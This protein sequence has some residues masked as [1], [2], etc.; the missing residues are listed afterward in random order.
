ME[1]PSQRPSPLRAQRPQRVNNFK[2]SFNRAIQGGPVFCWELRR[3]RLNI[4]NEIEVFKRDWKFQAG[5]FFFSRFSGKK[6]Q[7]QT[8]GSGY[9]PVVGWRSSMWRRGGPRSS[10]CPISLSNFKGQPGGGVQKRSFPIW[11]RLSFF[12]SV[13]PFFV[14]FFVLSL[15]HRNRSDVCDF[16]VCDAHR[17][18]QKFARFLR[19]DKAMLHCDLKVRW[20]VASDLRF[21]A[22][23]SEPKTPSFCGI[24]GDLAQSN[25]ILVRQGTFPM[26]SGCSRLVRGFFQFVLSSFSAF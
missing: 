16:C 8:F 13:C 6:A 10:V 4:S 18:P 23:I 26:L 7:T 22:A 19:Q 5:L 14:L 3:S 9:L 25:A 21:R 11:T 12:L 24:S 20:K 17:G 2:I 1:D 15:A